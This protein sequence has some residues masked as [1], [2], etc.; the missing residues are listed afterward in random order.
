MFLHGVVAAVVPGIAIVTVTGIV[1][2][3]ITGIVIIVITGVIVGDIFP[4][5]FLIRQRLT[6][7]GF[8][9]CVQLEMIAGDTA[10]L[11]GRRPDDG[12]KAQHQN[13][14]ER[15]NNKHFVKVHTLPSFL[16]AI[17][18]KLSLQ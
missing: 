6:R 4:W 7:A 8:L 11:R 10:A 3:A 9:Q 15:E 13:Q 14:D 18:R 16:I 5:L 17:T 12:A 1:I 2:V